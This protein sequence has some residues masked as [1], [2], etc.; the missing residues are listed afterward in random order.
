MAPSSFI[1]RRTVQIRSIVSQGDNGKT[2]CDTVP[3]I[4]S[5]C[6][7]RSGPWLKRAFVSLSHSWCEPM[8]GRLAG[9]KP[10]QQGRGISLAMGEYRK[11]TY[12][13]ITR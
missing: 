6:P 10:L 12:A 1:G 5:V 4:R 13:K 2:R 11:G 9:T 8:V 7:A 3:A